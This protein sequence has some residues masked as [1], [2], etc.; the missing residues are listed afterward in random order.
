MQYSIQNMW[1][2][3]SNSYKALFLSRWTSWVS[4]T[5][6]EVETEKEFE[7]EDG[8]LLT[9][10]PLRSRRH[11]GNKSFTDEISNLLR[12]TEEQTKTKE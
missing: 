5:T 8:S 12:K 4:S 9:T 2:R 3:E 7:S 1:R 11:P 6:G 10:N